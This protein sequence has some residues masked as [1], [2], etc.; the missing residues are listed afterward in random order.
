MPAKGR[1]EAW[2][3]L[4][5]AIPVMLGFVPFALVLGAQAAGKGFTAVEVPLMTG[6]NFGGGSEFAAVELWSSPPHVLLIAAITFLVNSRHLLMG[7]ALAPFIRHL[8]KRQALMA[9]FFMCDESWAMGLADARKARANL[10]LGYF[11]GVALGLYICWVIFTTVG[12][13]VGPILGD[14]TEYGF[15]MAFPAVFLVMLA[16]MWKGAKAALP[17]LVSL[18]VAAATYLVLPGAWYVP[19]GALSGVVAAFL[20]ARADG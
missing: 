13:L 20:M 12:V 6:L 19:A 7:A 11:F 10:S 15:D 16:G 2:R 3:G 5:A 9:Q 14:V 4:K 17:W 18:L 8:S 1:S